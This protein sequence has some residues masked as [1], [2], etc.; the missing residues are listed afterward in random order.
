MDTRRSVRPWSRRHFLG[1]LGA[2]GG[3]AL[4][5]A[6]SQP[7]T[8]APSKPAE[9]KPAETKPAAP[10]AAGQPTAA[11]AAKPDAKPA[12]KPASAPAAAQPKDAESLQT[13]PGVF[14]V[15]FNANWNTVTD[16]KIGQTFVEWGQQNGV[17]VEWQSI[18]GSPQVLAKQSAAVAAGQPP[19]VSN[20]NLVYW[21]TQKELADL[22]QIA[23]KFK[24]QGGG[25]Y[26]IGIDSLTATDG[27]VFG[28]PYGIDVWPPQW[29][30]D[31][32]GAVNNG[33]LFETWDKL[34]ELGPK[35]QKPPRTYTIAFCL[36][37]EGDHMNN[38]LT[39][40][41]GYGGRLNDE[42]GVPDIKNP[43]NKPAIE[44]IKRMWDAKIIPPD[45]F[46]Q[47]VTSW[48]NETYQ[49]GRAL[50]A[51]N[52][53]TIM[54][55]LLVND[56][57]LANNTGISPNPAGP[58]GTFSEGSALAFNYFTKAKLADKAPS[59]L[60][61]FVA[62][63]RMLNISKAVEGRFVPVYRDHTQGDFWQTSKFAEM[64]VIAENGRVRNWPSPQQPWLAE[65]TDARYTISD[66]LNKV[67]NEGM[68]I[69]DAQAWAQTELMDSYNKIV[70]P[71]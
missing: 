42:K 55:W 56:K 70:K 59:A 21:Y 29:R 9:T 33:K 17:K 60:E 14:N 2:F 3:A 57:E 63:E 48:N 25:M 43:A 38:V 36:G 18:P 51:I 37:H 47:T 32:I 61:Y 46:A 11:P 40:A 62:P 15:W 6:C 7:S 1:T 20:Q 24:S 22:K 31:E 10:A 34:I 49:K 13:V 39:V 4:V 66:M 65:V 30:I 64:R 28:V 12:D 53:A 71:A 5:A 27:G 35:A 50:M 16:E 52:P 68:A 45:T 26:P 67:L 23:E 58:Q 69:E 19:E 44:T 41:W 54:G 8:P